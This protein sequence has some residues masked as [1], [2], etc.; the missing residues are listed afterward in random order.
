MQDHTPS[1]RDCLGIWKGQVDI[2]D[3]FEPLPDWLQE[4]FDGTTDDD[5]S[6]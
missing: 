6:R 1:M 4:L 5:P 3:P 2:G